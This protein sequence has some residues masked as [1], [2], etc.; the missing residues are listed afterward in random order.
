MKQGI[1]FEFS[2]P[3]LDEVTEDKKSG[4][5]VL[6]L[7]IGVHGKIRLLCEYTVSAICYENKDVICGAKIFSLIALSEL[8]HVKILKKLLNKLGVEPIGY[9]TENYEYKGLIKNKKALLLDGIVREKSII[10]EIEKV[11]SLLKNEKVKKVLKQIQYDEERHLKI[12]KEQLKN[13][14][15]Y[16]NKT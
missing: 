2:Y 6:P 3:N 15:L 7:F 1:S 4:Y 10:I 16:A 8:E 11:N 12:L 5:L 13:N 14:F 9:L